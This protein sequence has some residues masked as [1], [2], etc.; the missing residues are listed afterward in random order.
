MDVNL[1]RFLLGLAIFLFIVGVY[2]FIKNWKK[3]NDRDFVN[4]GVWQQNYLTSLIVIISATSLFTTVIAINSTDEYNK[5]I[6]EKLGASTNSL[7]KDVNFAGEQVKLLQKKFDLENRPLLELTGELHLQLKNG[8]VIFFQLPLSDRKDF[9]NVLMPIDSLDVEKI[10]LQIS[11]KNIGNSPAEMRVLVLPRIFTNAEWTAR[12]GEYNFAKTEW[13]SIVD[14]ENYSS[15]ESPIL[16]NQKATVFFGVFELQKLKEENLST[17]DCVNYSCGFNYHAI[18]EYNLLN[19]P[20]KT[21]I[22]DG[23]LILDLTR[24]TS[25]IIYNKLT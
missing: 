2:S 17:F 6:V 24:G 3:I 22:T 10:S 21:Y 23:N 1:Y 19:D 7:A 13:I 15:S 16:P 14:Y 8:E 20:T 12:V 11:G 25:Q 9:E 18:L 5:E 4:S